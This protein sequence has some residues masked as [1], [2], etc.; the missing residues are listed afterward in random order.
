M[1]IECPPEIICPHTITLYVLCFY[2]V[3]FYFL[4]SFV[5]TLDFQFNYHLRSYHY[6]VSPW[7]CHS[8]SKFQR[9]SSLHHQLIIRFTMKT[10]L[11]FQWQ[12][13]QAASYPKL[14]SSYSEHVNAICHLLSILMNQIVISVQLEFLHHTVS[15]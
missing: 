4:L 3:T 15:W 5:M 6:L 7:V 10:T 11:I 13:N 12:I 2:S 9:S 1:S 14:L 8:H